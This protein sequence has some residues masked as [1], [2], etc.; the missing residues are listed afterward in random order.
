M[1]T[2]ARQV[3][4]Q[5][6][7]SGVRFAE[8]WFTDLCGKPWRMD[9]AASHMNEGVFREGITLDG[10]STG[11]PWRGLFN[12]M[13]DARSCFPDPAA[14]AATMAVFCDVRD[15]ESADASLDSRSTLGRAERRLAEC[16]VAEHLVLGAECE[17]FLL[18]DPHGPPACEEAVWDFLR[19]LAL[20]L[21]RAGISVE[22][23]RFGPSAGQGRVQMKQDAALKI[24]DQVQLYQ[25][26][27][28]ALARRD[29][30]VATFVPKPLPGHGAASLPVHHSLWSA[31]RNLFHDDGGW[32]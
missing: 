1:T 22:G 6:E 26:V 32:A 8:W 19:D 25:Y 18:E 21:G 7:E 20:A 5:I 13:P 28:K 14:R 29:G 9:V 3:L 2:N 17:F 27:A 23:F 15:A 16:G 4:S 10:P 11:R 30:K 31:G 24:A 12:L